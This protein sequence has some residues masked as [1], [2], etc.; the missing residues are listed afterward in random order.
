VPIVCT[1]DF[2]GDGKADWLWQEEA[3]GDLVVWLMNGASRSSYNY[4]SIPRPADPLWKVASVA[5]MNG[6]G[7]PD[8]VWQHASSGA[9]AAW[10]MNG[11]TVVD[12]VSVD[13]GVIADV[14]WKVVSTG[15]F[16]G[17]GKTDLLWKHMTSGYLI[18]WMMNGVTRTS[19]EWLSPY[20]LVDRE[21]QIAGG[22]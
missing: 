2:N 15:D 4:L 1:G 11:T 7:T 21:W 9:L 20:Q 22:R 17:D 5:D 14:N 19:V 18:V 10:M 12:R 13:P 3:A 8:L 6:D 16:N